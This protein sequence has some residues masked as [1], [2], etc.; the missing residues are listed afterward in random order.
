MTPS[1]IDPRSLLRDI[2][3][4]AHPIVG[5]S[6]FELGLTVVL[7]V[8]MWAAT[9]AAVAS[10]TWLGLLLAIPAGGLLLRLFVIQHDCGHG[11]LFRRRATNDWVGRALSVLTLTPYDSWRRSHARAPRDLGQSVQA[12]RRA[13]S[14]R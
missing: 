8:L 1:T 10:G 14:I 11:S 12:R 5:R 13:I 2:A 3:P 4:F 6:L 9:W 7:F